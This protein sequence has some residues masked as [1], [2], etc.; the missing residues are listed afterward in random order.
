MLLLCLLASFTIFYTDN[1]LYKIIL[2]V[3]LICYGTFF[4]CS[5][6]VII[7]LDFFREGNHI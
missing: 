2:C 4:A 6:A 7:V 1:Y 3:L 5:D